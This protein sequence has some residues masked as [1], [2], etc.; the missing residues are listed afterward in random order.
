MDD[1][2]KRPG[3]NRHIA[4]EA[5]DWIVKLTSGDVT[6]AEL[7]RFKAWRD[8]SPEH[9]WA[10]DRERTFWKQ[11]QVLDGKSDGMPPFG[12]PH[13]VRE[14]HLSRRAFVLGGGAI[15][16]A[17]AAVVVAPGLDLWW[18]A[19]F[20]TGV[21]D[22]AEVTLPD[23]SVATLNTD[24]AIALNFRP[25]LRLVNL[26]KGEAAFRVKPNSSLFRV[27]A[28]G[29][30]SDAPES[31]FAVKALDD[32]AT[33]TV[34]KG[35]VRVSGPASPTDPSGHRANTVTLAASQQTIYAAGG[36]PGPA[37]T[38]DIQAALAWRNG[39]VIFE[40]RPFAA[41]LA[42]LGRYLPERIVTAPGVDGEAPV[43][44]VFSTREALAAV[45][46]LAQTQGRTARR[47][48]GVVLLIS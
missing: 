48:P 44:A 28:L 47:I 45:Q 37:A 6:E 11:L 20:R 46:A 4:W 29:G 2:D 18:N 31:I 7:G 14:P 32:E 39:R 19:D 5:R 10:F 17:G 1:S 35:E 34:M 43:S 33:V 26:L 25:D 27:A 30:N 9:K 21:G 12:P 36:H 15:A 22:R 8:R 41:A 38:V 24:S 16:A 42:E 23:G 13:P 40:G 3:I